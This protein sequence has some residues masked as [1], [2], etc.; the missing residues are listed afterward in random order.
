MLKYLLVKGSCVSIIL[1]RSSEKN[2]M[3]IYLHR[4]DDKT[5]VAKGQQLQN[6]NEEYARVLCTILEIFLKSEFF[7]NKFEN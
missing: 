6:L 5:H 2:H 3:N 4:V 1:S 7:K